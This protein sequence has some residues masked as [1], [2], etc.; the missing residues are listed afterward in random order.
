MALGGD[1]LWFV[2]KPRALAWPPSA[3][4]PP[5]LEVTSYDLRAG[6]WGQPLALGETFGKSREILPI[7]STPPLDFA[8]LMADEKIRYFMLENE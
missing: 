1:R 7:F 2:Y 6:S 4:P 5:V 8:Y 3:T